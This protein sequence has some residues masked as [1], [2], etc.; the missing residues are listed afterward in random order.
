M[1]KKSLNVVLIAALFGVATLASAQTISGPGLKAAGSIS[2]D[3]EG[4]PTVL[5]GSDEDA[6]FLL[7]YAHARDRFFQMDY[8][9]RVASG[10]YAEL[11]GP[12]A[13]ASDVQQQFYDALKAEIPVER[14][15]SQWQ[16]LIEQT[17]Q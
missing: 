10:T 7:G 8:L 16:K 6:A 3:A 11:V 5:A 2:Y 4:V 15:D 9:R 12:A 17:D 14:D 1:L 13:L